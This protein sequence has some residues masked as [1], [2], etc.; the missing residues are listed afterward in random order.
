MTKLEFLY[1]L[2]SSL[3][4]LPQKEV[5]ERVAFYSEMIDDYMEEG[6]SEEQ[7]TEKIGSV[8]S[9]AKQIANDIPLS[10]IIK[11]KIKPTKKFTALEIVLIAL[12]SPIWLSIIISLF[13]VVFSVVASFWA[14]VVSLWA[15]FISLVVCGFGMLVYTV[16]M[17]FSSSTTI[18]LA[19]L[20]T[21]IVSL[22]LSLLFIV[23]CKLV[24][25]CMIKL[26]KLTL[27]LIKRAFVKK[28]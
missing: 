5:S 24:T 15:G 20:A 4:G 28:V 25:K 23:L 19:S 3:K 2:E 1:K 7:A 11:E 9:I 26:T 17:L 6:L 14:G 16:I 13:A 27:Q 18:I 21:A 8:N 12:G 10:K 22:G